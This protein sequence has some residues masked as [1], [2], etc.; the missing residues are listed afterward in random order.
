MNLVMMLYIAVRNFKN[1]IVTNSIHNNFTIYRRMHYAGCMLYTTTDEAIIQS[2]S[3]FIVLIL[4]LINHLRQL[5][6]SISRKY[7]L[8]IE[9]TFYNAMS[10]MS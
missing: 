10:L 6:E 4:R 3:S 1:Q 5:C 2:D 9:V 7:K 8:I